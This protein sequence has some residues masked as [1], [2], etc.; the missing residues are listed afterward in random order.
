MDKCSEK[1]LLQWLELLFFA[2]EV[3]GIAG[4]LE[5]I[6]TAGVVIMCGIAV[7][8]TSGMS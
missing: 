7:V 8:T 2:M 5:G 1:H 4:T 6:L 3:A